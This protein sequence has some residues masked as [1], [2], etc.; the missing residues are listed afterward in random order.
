[1]GRTACAEPQCLY[2]GALYCYL[3]L[4][5]YW[6]RFWRTGT[7]RH[8]DFKSLPTFRTITAPSFSGSMIPD[9]LEFAVTME[10]LRFS[11]TSVC[12]YPSTRLQIPE[13]LNFYEHSCKELYTLFVKQRFYC[14]TS[15]LAE[16]L[17][18]LRSFDR[19]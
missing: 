10:T 18:K 13:D 14:V 6:R 5:L 17:S 15:Y 4:Y 16:K 1:M 3:Y 8:V 19:Q 2:K 7:L 9:C 12:I 11:K